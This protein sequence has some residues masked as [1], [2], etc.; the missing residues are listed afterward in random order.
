MIKN[1]EKK[2]KDKTS[3]S[4]VTYRIVIHITDN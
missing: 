1:C 2:E 4:C 3:S